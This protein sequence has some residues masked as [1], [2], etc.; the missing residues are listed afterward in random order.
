MP[1]YKNYE[2][3]EKANIKMKDIHKKICKIEGSWLS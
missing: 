1:I 2:A 3:M